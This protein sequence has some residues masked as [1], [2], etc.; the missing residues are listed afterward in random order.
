MRSRHCEERQRR[1]NP[2]AALQAGLLR[3]ARNEGSVIARSASD[4]AIQKPALQPGLLRF[5]SLRFASLRFASL[6][7]TACVAIQLPRRFAGLLRYGALS[8]D[9]VGIGAA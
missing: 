6:A 7:M 4:E 5:A 3:F 1:S 2:D 8:G 9:V